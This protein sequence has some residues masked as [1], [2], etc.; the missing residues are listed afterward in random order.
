MFERLRTQ[1]DNSWTVLHSLGL[2]RHPRK[3][4]A[5]IDFVAV[6]AAGVFCFEVKGGRVRRENGVWFFKDRFNR[7]SSKT[8]GPWDQV[9]SASGALHQYLRS[10]LPD[11]R[12]VLVGSGVMLP[13]VVFEETGPDIDLETLYDLRDKDRGI[14]SFVKRVEGRWRRQYPGSSRLS[15]Q[16]AEAVVKCLRPDFDVHPPLATTV[17]EIG[18][19]QRDLSAEQRAVMAAFAAN[20]R[21]LVEGGPGTGKTLLAIQEAKRWAGMDPNIRVLLTCFN[22]NL[23]TLLG[24]ILRDEPRIQVRH[25]HGLMDSLIDLAELTEELAAPPPKEASQEERDDH[26]QVR[27]PVLA[28]EAL[29]KLGPQADVLIIDEGQDLMSSSF[30][31]VLGALLEG[32]FQDGCWRLFLDPVQDLYGSLDYAALEGIRAARPS[33]MRLNTNCR[34]TAQIMG[35]AATLSEQDCTQDAE[36]DG[37]KVEYYFFST[38]EEQADLVKE[39]VALL[40]EEGLEPNQITLLSRYR[41]DNEKGVM[42]HISDLGVPLCVLSEEPLLPDSVAFSTV[43]GFKGLESDAVILLDCVELSEKY[44]ATHYVGATRAKAVLKVMVN[45][46]SRHRLQELRARFGGVEN[47]TDQP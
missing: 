19:S 47:G 27:Y 14:S 31:P 26:F 10:A 32:G 39:Q 45:R 17:R 28:L 2:A 37:P 35:A 13:G 38:I 24:E 20:D 41:W 29:E 16:D 21:V 25:L 23:A 33:V 43:T 7:E 22:W 9:G 18:S 30:T 15:T 46:R 4:R 36:L 42:K 5:E 3:P 40:L 1:L 11:I 44:A 34:S 6:G 8:E 12:D